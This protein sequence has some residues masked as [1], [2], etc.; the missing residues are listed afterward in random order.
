MKKKYREASVGLK[1]NIPT[2]A[3]NQ[4]D[5]NKEVVF[6]IGQVKIHTYLTN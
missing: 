5:A 4:S 3:I 2:I 6:A 1:N